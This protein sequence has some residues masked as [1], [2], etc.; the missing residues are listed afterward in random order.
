MTKKQTKNTV[1]QEQEDYV[2]IHEF[3]DLKDGNKVYRKGE[4]FNSKGK[5]EARIKELTTSYNAI[6]ERLIK[7]K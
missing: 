6:G 2:V 1:K 7:L 5:S 3:K 4:P